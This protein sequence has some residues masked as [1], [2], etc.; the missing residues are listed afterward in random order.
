MWPTADS[1]LPFRS[2]SWIR[3]V[4]GNRTVMGEHIAVWRRRGRGPAHLRARITCPKTAT[5]LFT[6]SLGSASMP[7]PELRRCP[8]YGGEV[9]AISMQSFGS[10]DSPERQS[11]L[12]TA[13]SRY[14]PRLR[15]SVP[16]TPEEIS[17]GALMVCKAICA[18]CE[19]FGKDFVSLQRNDFQPEILPAGVRAMNRFRSANRSI[20]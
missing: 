9:T 19:F 3:Q 1:T 18:S 13:L 8:Q 10:F 7:M 17:M 4:Q 11:S 20:L 15:L 6:Y 16:W 2:G 14:G 5:R 12:C